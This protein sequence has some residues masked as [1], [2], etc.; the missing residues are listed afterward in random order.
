[1]WLRIELSSDEARRLKTLARL[2]QAR[3]S[4]MAWVPDTSSEHATEYQLGMA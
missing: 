2:L 4:Q 3:A 1:M